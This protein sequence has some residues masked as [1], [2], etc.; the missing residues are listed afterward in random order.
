[1]P[2]FLIGPRTGFVDRMKGKGMCSSGFLNQIGNSSALVAGS[3]NA[4]VYCSSTGIS[5]GTNNNDNVLQSWVIPANIFD[6]AGRG[7]QLTVMGSVANNVNSKR[8]KI[9]A[10]CTTATVG[11]AVTGGTTIADSGAYTTAGAAGFQLAAQ[12][13]KTGA[14]GSNT[15]IAL[16]QSSTIG[17]TSGAL[18][19]PSALTLNESASWILAVTGNAVTTNTDI[20]LNFA[21]LFV[22][23]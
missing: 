6:I 21:E 20:V 14:G 4:A 5:P 10:G 2:G 18:V 15:Q 16:H 17:A 12:I 7:M 1:M 22:T 23:N 19:V 13:F 11:S 8:I 3:G 9:I